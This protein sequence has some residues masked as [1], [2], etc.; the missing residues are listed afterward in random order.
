MM[1]QFRDNTKVIFYRSR[2]FFPENDHFLEK[3]S[4]EF[5]GKKKQE[6]FIIIPIFIIFYNL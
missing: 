6:S 3:N 1:I 2:N 4:R 5:S